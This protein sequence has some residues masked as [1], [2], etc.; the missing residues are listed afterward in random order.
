MNSNVFITLTLKFE[1]WCY[2]WTLL[3]FCTDW[4]RDDHREWEH[5]HFTPDKN[6]LQSSSLIGLLIW[7]NHPCLN[8]VLLCDD[9]LVSCNYWTFDS[10]EIIDIGGCPD[11]I[12]QVSKIKMSAI[13]DILAWTPKSMRVPL[14][15]SL[16]PRSS[17]D[18]NVPTRLFVESN[19]YLQACRDNKKVW[20]E[21]LVHEFDIYPCKLILPKVIINWAQRLLPCLQPREYPWYPNF[22]SVDSHSLRL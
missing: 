10:W 14:S 4:Q 6:I 1:E 2:N 21:M 17:K 12:F 19:K 5:A 11:Q 13:L 22:H 18:R 3:P 15:G 7:R 8:L 9:F 20:G 16:R